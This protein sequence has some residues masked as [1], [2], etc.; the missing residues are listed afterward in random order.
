LFDSLKNVEGSAVADYIEQQSQVWFCAKQCT[1]NPLVREIHQ[2]YNHIHTNL[3]DSIADL[4]KMCSE[5][6]R[7]NLVNV[8]RIAV[9]VSI[10][11]FI[12]GK[13]W[14]S[15]VFQFLAEVNRR[16]S[17]LESRAV[18]VKPPTLEERKERR[19]NFT[20]RVGAEVTKLDGS[21]EHPPKTEQAVQ[22]I[23][24]FKLPWGS[25]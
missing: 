24:K 25:E 4:K 14:P 8:G 17:E 11:D 15:D 3:P 5:R 7:V 22:L 20:K 1:P 23:R 6:P 13:P 18:L 2:A 21:P 19:R 9:H 16:R 12:Q 10:L